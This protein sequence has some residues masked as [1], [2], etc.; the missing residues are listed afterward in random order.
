MTPHEAIAELEKDLATLKDALCI[1]SDETGTYYADEADIWRLEEIIDVLSSAIRADDSIAQYT[2][3]AAARFKGCSYHT[4]SRAVRSGRLPASR[5]GHNRL[6]ARDDLLA[7]KPKLER[8]PRQYRG[9]REPQ[10]VLPKIVG[11]VS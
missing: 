9:M 7:W 3:E 2:M 5:F 11:V 4:V 6:I 1:H 10:M 8:A